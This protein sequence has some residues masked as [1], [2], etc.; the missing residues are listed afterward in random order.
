LVNLLPEMTYTVSGRT[1]NPT[2]TLLNT[3]LQRFVLLCSRHK[4]QARRKGGVGGEREYLFAK[5][6]K[7]N[8]VVQY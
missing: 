1:L 7:Y 2:L 6:H 8:V 4:K 5:K 3:T